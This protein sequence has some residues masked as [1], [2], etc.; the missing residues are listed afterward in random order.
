MPHTNFFRGLKES[1][2]SNSEIICKA[3]NQ[4]V[5]NSEYC[6][7][8]INKQ[9]QLQLDLH[10][11]NNECITNEATTSIEI[12]SVLQNMTLVLKLDILMIL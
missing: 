2:N 7:L 1:L 4:T 8:E 12:S 6:E 10:V 3:S 9:G 5:N 11:E